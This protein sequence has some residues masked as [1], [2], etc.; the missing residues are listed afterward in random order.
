MKM[1]LTSKCTYK[2]NFQNQFTIPVRNQ[3]LLNN[4]NIEIIDI[5][6]VQKNIE[7]WKMYKNVYK[8]IEIFKDN[9]T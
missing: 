4:K 1:A 5:F 7:I 6:K 9:V 8:N 2:H 3:K